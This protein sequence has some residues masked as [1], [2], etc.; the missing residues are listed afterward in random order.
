MKIP[1]GMTEQEV[2]DSIQIVVD[3]I[4]PKYIF[5]GWDLLDIK[6]EAFIICMSALERYQQGH[7]LENFLSVNLSNRLKN[8]IRDN[9]YVRADAEEKKKIMMPGQLSKEESTKFY[10]DHSDVQMDVSNLSML[11]DKELPIKYRSNYLKLVN[12]VSV[13]KKERE[14]LLSIIKKIATNNGFLE[15]GEEQNEDEE[16]DNDTYSTT[17]KTTHQTKSN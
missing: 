16:Q 2:I 7:P 13:P 10:Y 11:I 9:H 12:G 14:E 17:I 3:R 5:P 1:K 6:Q 15:N 4:S 8:L